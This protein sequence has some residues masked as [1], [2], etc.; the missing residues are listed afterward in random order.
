MLSVL[1]SW[2][3]RCKHIAQAPM[4]LI[5]QYGSNLVAN[6]RRILQHIHNPDMV[7]QRQLKQGTSSAVPVL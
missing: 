7:Y 1:K 4:L 3:R 2:Q 5:E 6:C